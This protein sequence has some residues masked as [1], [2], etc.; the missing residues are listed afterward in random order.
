[1]LQNRVNTNHMK[2]DVFISYRR[3]GGEYTAKILKD[4]LEDLGY[5]V[6]F[7]VESLRSG[8]FN[9]KLYSV[10]EECQ[11]FILI[12][13]PNSLERCSNED[14]WVQAEIIHAIKCKK[15]I[16]PIML[17]GFQFPE[18]LPEEIDI[19]RMK[20]G[21][22]SNSEFFDAF[23]NRLQTF[24]S[25]KPSFKN[26]ITQNIIF[27]RTLPLFLAL[28]ILLVIIVGSV[29][30]YTNSNKIYPKTQSEKNLTGEV[31]VYISDNIMAA[32]TISGQMNKV[33]AACDDF[34]VN[35]DDLSYL[36]V[37]DSLNE[38]DRKINGINVAELAL[39]DSL[40]D[41]LDDSRFDKVDIIAINTMIKTGQT[42]SINAILRI[43]YI[44]DPNHI[45]DLSTRQQLITLDQ[46]NSDIFSL[47]M[48]YS[49]NY[50]LLPVSE[51]YSDLK[52]F[53]TKVIPSLTNLPFSNYFWTNDEI[54][55]ERLI[56]S[57]ISQ[58]DALIMERS[59]IVGNENFA[60]LELKAEVIDQL[61]SSG[62]SQADAEAAAAEV[63]K[64]DVI[65]NAD[66]TIE[67]K[68]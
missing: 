59:T 19:I 30:V 61:I 47:Q 44:L 67:L 56:M 5:R 20:S 58:Q 34:M 41:G 39:S 45:L 14:D 60:L 46:K 68:K 27:R 10:I 49:A 55:L 6:F 50:L 63:I 13:S 31:I 4:R 66:G 1:M 29:T 11:D 17:R 23:I 24:L 3:D 65:K 53:K 37:I 43:K 26:R 9:E 8:D 16:I 35:K 52:D 33:Y 22:E 54:E 40:S 62:Y 12:L 42:N 2:Y 28:S 21:L 57:S 51:S 15:N 48:V 32:D 7:D 64:N 36:A 38:A 25:A 18:I